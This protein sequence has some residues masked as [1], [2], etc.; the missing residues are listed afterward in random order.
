MVGPRI[1]L[2]TSFRPSLPWSIGISSASPRMGLSS[3]VPR[4]RVGRSSCRR[5]ARNGFVPWR[6]P[7]E[8]AGVRSA[9]GAGG[10]SGDSQGRASQ[11][12]LADDGGV[13][14]CCAQFFAVC[15]SVN[16]CSYLRPRHLLSF[17]DQTDIVLLLYY[18][19]YQ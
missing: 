18:Y 6:S 15:R 8:T 5:G 16:T 4:P 12:M 1:T 10:G 7:H 3:A 13:A 14:T 17:L 11:D 9:L 2:A 19:L